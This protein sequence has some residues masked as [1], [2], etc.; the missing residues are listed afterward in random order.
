M[1]ELKNKKIKKIAVFLL[2]VIIVFNASIT[3]ASTENVVKLGDANSDGVIDAADATFILRYVVGLFRVKATNKGADANKD[4]VVDAA[5]ATL[6]LRAVAGL[7][8]LNTDDDILSFDSVKMPDE[9]TVIPLGE[10]FA[11]KGTITSAIT[12]LEYVGIRIYDADDEIEIEN[13]VEL[14]S[15]SKTYNLSGFKGSLNTITKF[16]SLSDGDKRIE[17]YAANKSHEK[18]VYESTFKVE[19]NYECDMITKNLVMPDENTVINEGNGYVIKGTVVSY[20][21]P[22]KYVGVTITDFEG[23][24]EMMNVADVTKKNSNS[25][26][27]GGY[28]GSL[29]SMVKFGNLTSGAK[30]ITLYAENDVGFMT[31]YESEFTVK[32]KASSNVSDN[33]TFKNVNMPDENTKIKLGSS[34]SLKGTVSSES[35]NLKLVGMKIYDSDNETVMEKNVDVSA[36]NIKAYELSGYAGSLDSM[37]KFAQL[38]LGVKKIE[39]YAENSS[40]VQVLYESKF[41]IIPTSSSDY[42]VWIQLKKSDLTVYSYEI[43][44]EYFG[45]T[46][47]LF[48]YKHESGRNI[49]IDPVWVSE[50]IVTIDFFYGRTLYVNKRAKTAYENAIK[51]IENS[52]VLFKYNDGESGVFNLTSLIERSGSGAYT[53]RFQTDM[54]YISHH[55]FGTAVDINAGIEVNC[56]NKSGS[57]DYNW[58]KIKAAINLLKY[59]GIKTID[60]KQVYVFKYDGSKPKSGYVPD[61]LKN[62][63]LHELAFVREGFKWGGYFTSGA[64]AMHFTLTESRDSRRVPMVTKY[65]D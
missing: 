13:L 45:D 56:I 43:A 38:T 52:Y 36:K 55:S 50:N 28:S 46:S 3:G 14:S 59:E 17:L 57:T 29:N 18:V 26:E 19:G 60:G 22:L 65:T 49:T 53:P 33:I 5:D 32:G 31:L 39:L 12:N 11:I 27:I 62:Y 6:V 37:M 54:K 51:H 24:E 16:G 10:S 30:K 20:N 47:F 21:G 15:N 25:Y 64:D 40:G 35:S 44:L 23:N 9:N 1:I 8:V 4:G 58:N 61:T 34:Y 63:L 7:A 48:R 41:E 2:A 42:N